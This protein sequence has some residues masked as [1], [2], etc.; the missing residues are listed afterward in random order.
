MASPVEIPSILDVR[1]PIEHGKCLVRNNMSPIGNT[2]GAPDNVNRKRILVVDDNEVVVK[3]LS[4]KLQSA[5]YEVLKALDGP[6]ALTAARTEKPDLII[7][8]INFPTDSGVA[9]DGF[10]II[11]WLRRMDDKAMSIPIIVITGGDP[12]K[13]KDRSLAAG[14]VAFFHKPIKNEEL[15]AEIEKILSKPAECP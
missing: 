11:E 2:G 4:M 15:L 14:A 8:D 13:F 6:R 3:A 5:G 9:W 12:A 1:S 7:L 10:R